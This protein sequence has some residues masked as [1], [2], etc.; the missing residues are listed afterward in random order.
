MRVRG[1]CVCMHD[2]QRRCRYVLK[3]VACAR[4]TARTR[5]G[6]RIERRKTFSVGTES[7]G[8]EKGGYIAACV[9]EERDE[10]NRNPEDCSPLQVGEG[11][12]ANEREGDRF[13]RGVPYTRWEPSGFQR[14]RESVLIGS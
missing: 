11:R 7:S 10:K 13:T 6:G 4:P 8:G 3:P 12:N 9:V 1:V 14:E 5:Q 2:P